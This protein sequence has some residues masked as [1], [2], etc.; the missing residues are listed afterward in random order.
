MDRK[1]WFKQYLVEIWFEFLFWNS[2]EPE[3]DM[4][5]IVIRRYRFVQ[6]RD[7]GRWIKWDL[8]GSDSPVPAHLSELIWSTGSRSGGC[9]IKGREL[10]GVRLGFW[11]IFR[12]GHAGVELRRRSGDFWAMARLRRETARWGELE[13]LIG[14]F[15]CS[16]MW[17]GE[18]AGNEAGG[19]ALLS[20][21][22]RS[23]CCRCERTKG[24]RRSA[25]SWGSR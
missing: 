9:E 14:F 17:V 22:L 25:T 10:T 19:G 20:S 18:A 6:I 5:R 23:N 1:I 7:R 12:R 24:M 15:D 3:I 8:D 16:Q 11:Q 4:W 21:R 2:F 13:S